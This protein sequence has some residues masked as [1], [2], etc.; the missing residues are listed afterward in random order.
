MVGV[1]FVNVQDGGQLNL[2]NVERLLI[3]ATPP[4]KPSADAHDVIA[5][6]G[7][8]GEEVVV[9]TRPDR[10]EAERMSADLAA[11]ANAGGRR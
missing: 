1:I 8:T 4:P 7:R 3:K 5:V 2:A 6:I 11:R 9:V 10:R